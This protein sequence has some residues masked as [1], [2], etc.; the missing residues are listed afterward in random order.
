MKW[1]NKLE[2]K[3]GRY[4][5]SNLMY[6]I[7]LITGIIYLVQYVLNIPLTYYLA[8]IPS[9]IM[10]G[11]IWRIITFIFI[12]PSSSLIFIVFVLYFYY[13]IGNT[14]ENE[15]GSFKFNVYYLCGMIGTI[16]AAFLTGYGDSVYLNLSMFLAFA[17]LYPDLEV[18][19]FFFLPV[20]VK[21][22]AYLDWLIFLVNLIRGPMY[23]RGAIIA[24]LIN[25]FIFFG[26][27]F[28]SF[29]KNQK[30]YGA[31]RRNFKREMKKYKK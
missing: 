17:Y 7:I 11:Q 18:R 22:L 30:R 12:P 10:Q 20:K 29:L 23:V 2:R 6:Y 9:Q 13:M 26:G 27:D 3:Y 24:A 28:V 8:F 14:L 15:W 5:I 16:I 21:W 31:T 25:V 1:L 4:A 19:L